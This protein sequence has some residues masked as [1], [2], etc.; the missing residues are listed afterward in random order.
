MAEP[1]LHP[2]IRKWVNDIDTIFISLDQ[3]TKLTGY[4]VW[5]NGEYEISGL[6]DCQK[7]DALFRFDEMVKNIFQIL[8]NYK[9]IVV[10]IED[11][12]MQRNAKVLKE[13][14]QLQGAIV[15]YCVTHEIDIHIIKP[16]EWRK[17]LGFEQGRGVKRP[18]LKQQCFKWVKENLGIEKSEDEVEAIGIGA[19]V[20]NKFRKQVD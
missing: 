17:E 6:L 16:T 5:R 11:T 13:L 9:P 12:A 4:C 1:T 14:S 19:A 15:G 10:Y 20:L 2:L 8:D 18:E 3:S 7:V